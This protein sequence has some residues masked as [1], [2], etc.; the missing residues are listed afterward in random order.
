MCL[1]ADH[2]ADI[3]HWI[4]FICRLTSCATVASCRRLSLLPV[5]SFLACRQLIPRATNLW[6]AGREFVTPAEARCLLPLGVA[7]QNELL[8]LCPELEAAGIPWVKYFWCV[9]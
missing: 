9:L 8:T 6:Q 2:Q 4:Y 1:L 5:C 3:P 7:L